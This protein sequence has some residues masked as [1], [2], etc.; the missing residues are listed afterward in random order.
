MRLRIPPPPPNSI[1]SALGCSTLTEEPST[2]QT[3]ENHL[4]AKC[5][6]NYVK[7]VK[8]RGYQTYTHVGHCGL[9]IPLPP[10]NFIRS[11]LGCSTFTEE[12]TTA[13][14]KGNHLGTKCGNNYVKPVNPWPALINYNNLTHAATFHGG[15]LGTVAV[16][17]PQCRCYMELR[18]VLILLH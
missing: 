7:P 5:G 2:A 15:G 13:Q 3:K 10:P 8:H 17:S 9:L 6:N 12:P 4:G 18:E 14:T 16:N 11:A 1:Q